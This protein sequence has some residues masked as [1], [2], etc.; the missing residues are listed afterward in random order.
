MTER[1]T[2][3]TRTGEVEEPV[4]IPNTEERRAAEPTAEVSS[5]ALEGKLTEE[6]QCDEEV[7]GEPGGVAPKVPVLAGRARR[8]RALR[9]ADST[10]RWRQKLTGQQRL[11]MLDTWMRSKLP[12]SEFAPM[13]GI[14]AHTLYQ[15]KRLFVEQG[16]AGLADR[17]R[18]GPKGSRLPEATRR[19]VL[20]MKQAHS[21]WGCE[22]LHD[23]LLRTEGYEASASAISKLLHEEGYEAEKV[24]TRSHPD[25]K[26]SFERARPNQL[27]QSDLFTFLLRRENRRVHLVV[28][29]DDHSR[30]V[31]SHGL[32]AT[33]SGALV[34][35]AL[36]A[37]LGNFGAPQEVLTDQGTQYYTWRGKSAF[38]RLL[39]RRGI[40]H[41]VARPRHPQT[42]GKVERF[43]GTLWRECLESSLFR[44]LDDARRRVGHFID[45]YNFLRTHQGLGGLV[46][47][48][49]YFSA[50]PE[51]AKTLRARVAD[52]AL[53]LARHGEPRK[54]FYLTGRVGDEGISLHAEGERVILTKADG[55]REEVN[56]KAPGRRAGPGESTAMPAPAAVGAEL[57]D[58]PSTVQEP[59][60]PAP[61]TSS[62]DEDLARIEHCAGEETP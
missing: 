28:F 20:M 57:A 19:A 30:F 11:L 23:M 43:W 34:R 12:A 8:S 55:T 48:D 27:W 22:R 53:E 21:E 6:T 29:L 37:G 61:G 59:E 18:G 50:A 58:L 31:V 45:H 51:V 62:L 17:P 5:D 35:E 46:P 38:T 7:V 2:G 39:E 60:E 36:D 33:A 14:S 54:S 26:R 47:A 13:V 9:K 1:P 52:N 25:K 41:V 42:L 4:G 3:D 24:E 49:R 15:W 32:H 16:P 10:E 40:R 56:L 44:G